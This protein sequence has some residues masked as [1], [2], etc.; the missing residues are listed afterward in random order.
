[1][2]HASLT[3]N[4]VVW[5][6]NPTGEIVLT[7]LPFQ[8]SLL[9]HQNDSDNGPF[10]VFGLEWA[11]RVVNCREPWLMRPLVSLTKKIDPKVPHS[12]PGT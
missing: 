5:N 6:F 10:S 8:I 11:Q 3:S 2:P 12:V 7:R 1:M 4:S 9:P